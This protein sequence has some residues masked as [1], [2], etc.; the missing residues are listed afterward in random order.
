MVL[1]AQIYFDKSNAIN[2]GNSSISQM[3]LLFINVCI[4]A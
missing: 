1:N 3:P 4:S 2:R